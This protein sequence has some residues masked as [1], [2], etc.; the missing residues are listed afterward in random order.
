MVQSLPSTADAAR[1][2]VSSNAEE[3]DTAL[4]VPGYQL[5]D[6]AGEGGMGTVFRAKQL[7]LNRIVAVKILHAPCGCDDSLP[8]FHR[9]S[10]LLASLSHPNIV[11]IHDCG[12]HGGRYFLVTEFVLGSPL[13]AAMKP[14]KPWPIDRA[15]DMLARIAQALSY[16]H[17]HGVLHLDLKPE[18]VL[19][20][21]DG[22][23]K[24]ADFGLALARV[25]ARQL[26]DLGLAQGTLDYCAPEQRY[27][28]QT[29]ERSDLF[30]LGVLAY[31]LLTGH[32]PG[33]IYQSAVR[34]NRRLPAA[35][36]DLLRRA[37]SRQPEERFESV[38]E[39]NRQLQAVLH[40][41][42]ATPRR[43]CPL[44]ALAVALL[45]L[46][47]LLYPAIPL[48]KGETRNV[49]PSTPAVAKPA[50]VKGWLLYDEPESLHW[51]GDLGRDESSSKW[52]VSLQSLQPTGRY[53]EGSAAPPLPKWP[54]PRP[55]MVLQ[56][57]D[58]VVFLHPL[59]NSRLAVWVGAHWKEL[60]NTLIRPDD[61]FVRNGDFA[62]ETDFH[63]EADDWRAYHSPASGDAI[64]IEAPADRPENPALHL[65][66][67]DSS[68]QGGQL[69]LYQWLAR[70]PDRPGTLVIFRF[71]ARAQAGDGR[72]LLGP[73]LPLTIPRD[74]GSPAAERLRTLSAPHT[75]LPPGE[76][77]EAREYRPLDWV[78]PEANWRT[79]AIIWDWPEYATELWYRNIE[80]LFAGLGEV[81]VDDIEMF[82]WDQELIRE[83]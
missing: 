46:P 48:Q 35:V 32:L 27:G 44:A 53:P 74:D 15:A 65:I 24:I 33:R 19:C 21:P 79:Y 16:I 73:R 82:A 6:K 39:F 52:A 13:R 37:L 63:A 62:E 22:N 66:K 77:I 25:D 38:A 64:R 61:N 8:A 50:G 81:W 71:R 76:G 47:L 29:D 80:I 1:S 36:D 58:G 12:Q 51:F 20:T 69:G 30:S 49:R 5:L 70:T 45:L 67:Q 28:L 60:L 59:L 42:R 56:S 55:V 11:A 18:N 75:Q 34:L 68:K 23:I 17:Q 4:V 3:R 72:L 78:Q 2:L 26:C 83:K 31:E 10:R 7:S 43:R 54:R 9:E 57:P 40:P 14:G 41:K